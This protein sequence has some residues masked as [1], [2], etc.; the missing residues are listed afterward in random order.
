MA[1]ILNRLV[2]HKRPQE[3]IKG[4]SVL[5]Q[6]QIGLRIANRCGDFQSIADNAGVGH[7]FCHFVI[8]I[9][10][11]LFGIKTVKCLTIVFSLLQDG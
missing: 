9:F 11:N 2:L 4:I 7:E 6:G 1:I 5:F 10:G 3:L 8:P